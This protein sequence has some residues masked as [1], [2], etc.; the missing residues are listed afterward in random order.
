MLAFPIIFH[1][2]DYRWQTLS[3][4][5]VFS[6]CHLT[7]CNV[8]EA[9]K[10]NTPRCPGN[11]TLAFEMKMINHLPIT[12]KNVLSTVRRL[13]ISKTS[14][15]CN[16]LDNVTQWW[17]SSCLRNYLLRRSALASTFWQDSQWPTLLAHFDVPHLFTTTTEK[18]IRDD[19]THGHLSFVLD[20]SHAMVHS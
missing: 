5:P 10:K 12:E 15:Y 11:G 7:E 8:N 6:Q 20:V 19:N 1:S 3:S 18:T 16:D 17:F 9:L 13:Q 14:Q 2:V 4:N